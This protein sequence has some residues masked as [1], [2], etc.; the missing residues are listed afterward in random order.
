MTRAEI[1]IV[2]GLKA[3]VAA[4]IGYDDETLDADADETLA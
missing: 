4:R 3:R 1:A 2:C